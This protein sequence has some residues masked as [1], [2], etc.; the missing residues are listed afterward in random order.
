MSEHEFLK[1]VTTFQS[2]D[3]TVTD[4]YANH[5]DKGDKLPRGRAFMRLIKYMNA[6]EPRTWLVINVNIKNIWRVE[7]ELVK[8]S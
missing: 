6:T 5:L 8:S 2:G 7:S 1:S 4:L 3:A